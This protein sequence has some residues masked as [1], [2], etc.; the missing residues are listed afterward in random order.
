[1]SSALTL[2][3][4][5]TRGALVSLANWPVVL[6]DFAVES[7]YKFALAVPVLGGVFMVAVLLGA[8]VRSLMGDGLVSAAD[9]LLVPLGQSPVALAAFALALTVVGF[10]GQILMF[11]IKAGTLAVLVAGEQ[12]AGDMQ[13]SSVRW[14]A[15]RGADVYAIAFVLDAVRRYGRRSAL[16]AAW[17]GAVYVAVGSLYLG[18][19]S[20]GFQWLVQSVW[21]SAWPLLVGLATST[22]VVTLTAA[23]LVF[24]LTRVVII[25]DDCRVS[26][27]VARVRTFL[28][29]DARQVLG[30]FGGMA[31]LVVLATAVWV[32]VTA[33]LTVVAFVPLAGILFV[34]LQAALW[35]VRGLF[36]QYAG[37][38]T[39]SAYQSQYRRFASPSPQAVSVQ[40]PS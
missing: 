27:A 30:I 1:M 22:G 20:Y 17:L 32:T 12:A 15:L 3:A 2:R 23:N 21:A 19:V 9:R 16:L 13:R 39:M 33:G 14:S 26:T 25:A 10:G 29:A 24:D 8:D 31:L 38:T 40:V 28:L 36:F 4:A 35:I 18:A 5:I 34:P 11:V 6:I 37:L 7:L